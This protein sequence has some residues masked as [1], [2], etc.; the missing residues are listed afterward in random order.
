MW[1]GRRGGGGGEGGEGGGGGGWRWWLSF[2][3]AINCKAQ[4][5]VKE[6]KEKDLTQN[7]HCEKKKV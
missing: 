2:E 1:R 7:V 6:K 5:T 3:E 4:G